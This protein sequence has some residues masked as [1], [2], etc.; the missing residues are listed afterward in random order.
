MSVTRPSASGWPR[1]PEQ[2]RVAM[3]LAALV[4]AVGTLALIAYVL[5][6]IVGLS[7]VGAILEALSSLDGD[8]DPWGCRP[9]GHCLL[10]S[11]GGVTGLGLASL[12]GGPLAWARRSDRHPVRAQRRG[13]RRSGPAVD[14]FALG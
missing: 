4:L 8:L 7:V 6:L 14:G 10:S 13:C 12:A 2:A 5:L 11:L 1:V 3:S 9:C